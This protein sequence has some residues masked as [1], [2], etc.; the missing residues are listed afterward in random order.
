MGEMVRLAGQALGRALLEVMA[1]RI[2]PAS[3]ANSMLSS[4]RS[5]K[6]SPEKA[7]SAVTAIML[8]GGENNFIYTFSAPLDEA[9]CEVELRLPTASS[10]APGKEILPGAAEVCLAPYGAYP[11]KGRE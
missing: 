8:D 7:L 4:W 10:A 2:P 9:L 1:S 5:G 6:V 3:D 11:R